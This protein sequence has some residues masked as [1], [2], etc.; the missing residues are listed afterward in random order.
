MDQR[1][2][3]VIST[4]FDLKEE[5]V[6]DELTPK[7]VEL[8]DSI[9]HLTLTTAIEEELGIQFTM[10]EIQSIDSISKLNHFIRSKI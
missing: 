5:D 4:L 1:V 10:D 7:D 3:K 8:W 6:H 2:R 9:N